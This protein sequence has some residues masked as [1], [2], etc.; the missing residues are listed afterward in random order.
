MPVVLRLEGFKFMFYAN[1]GAPREPIHIH[2]RRGR[3][4][5]K[6]WL[7]PT[8]SMAY[9]D[10]LNARDLNRAERLVVIH[11]DQLEE[12]WNEYFS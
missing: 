8:V 5:A 4:E 7:L 2:V 1:E 12:A 10:G 11:R 9:N 3:D 6:F